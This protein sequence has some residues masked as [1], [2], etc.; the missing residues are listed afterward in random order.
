MMNLPETADYYAS[1]RVMSVEKSHISLSRTIN[2]SFLALFIV[3]E[4]ERKQQP[5]KRQKKRLLG[6][7]D[8]DSF[9][10]LSESILGFLLS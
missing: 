2:S 9:L 10:T 3:A 5:N 7:I 6:K 8:L 4:K 1:L